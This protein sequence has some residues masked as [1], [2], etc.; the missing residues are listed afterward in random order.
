MEEHLRNILYNSRE[1]LKFFYS[2]IKNDVVWDTYNA[3]VGGQHI[4]SGHHSNVRLTYKN[5]NI[6]NNSFRSIHFNR[7]LCL[8]ELLIKLNK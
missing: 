4:N 7:D 5:I 6:E 2:T 3:S 8:L 1:E